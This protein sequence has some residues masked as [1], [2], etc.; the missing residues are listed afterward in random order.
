ML[1]GV[2]ERL[3]RRTPRV[4]T[5]Q[6]AATEPTRAADE[7]PPERRTVWLMLAFA[8]IVAAALRLPFLDHQSLWLDEIY[9]R[10]IIGD[11]SVSGL[12]RH[13]EATE[14]TPPLYYL[15]GWLAHARSTV[16]L[17]LTSAL[18]LIAAVPV[19]YLAFRR[20]VGRRRALATA[21]IL[22]VSPMLVWYSTDARSYGLFVLS[23]L[24]SV[25]AASALL[26]RGSSKRFALWT[27]ASA[28][29]VWTHYFGV[30]LVGAELAAIVVVR[31]EDRR[32]TAAWASLLAVCLSPLVPLIASQSGDERA[33]F[34]AGTPLTTRLSETVRQFG[35]GPNVPRTW[36][37]A[38]GLALFCPAVG[39]GI[40]MAVRAGRGPRSLLALAAIAFAA[41][42]L[43]AVLGIE[44]RFY[45]RNMIALAP[46]AAALAAPAM[47]RVRAAPLAVYLAL[48][49]VT[50]IWV[51]TD[52][53]YEQV[54]WRGALARAEALDRTAA[55]V[56]TTRESAPVV[57]TYLA[58]GPAPPSG[59][60]TRRAWIIVEPVRAAGNR[61]LGPA[62]IPHLLGFTTLRTL[63]LHAF[64]LVLVAA[65]RPTRITP[66][67]I[68]GSTIF[69]AGPA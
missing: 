1:S 38:A 8:T 46:I 65:S 16:A 32:A 66:G 26:E 51:A 31:R 20:L 55:V 19:G 48:A 43:P 52:W 9:T 49:T 69:P 56:A 6:A 27:A 22:A 35:M 54:D 57:E 68:V 13:I 17:R 36:L 61:A 37:E 53:R 67:E 44:D 2:L 25:W 14:S 15:I 47:L 29:C 59:V 28:A 4:A 3:E 41:P 10:Q 21:S 24:L 18:A 39:A 64:T 42:L 60:L 62:P 30:F 7:S 12:W 58:R 33:G 40:V 5:A 50:S 23:A 63:R 34:I 45:A 11:S